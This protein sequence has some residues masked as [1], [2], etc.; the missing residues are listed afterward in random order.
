[1]NLMRRSAVTFLAY[2]VIGAATTASLGWYCAIWSGV[3][4]TSV[5]RAPNPLTAAPQ[6]L[7]L[8]ASE[9]RWL[10]RRGIDDRVTP[11]LY[12]R[13]RRGFGL[14]ITTFARTADEYWFGNLKRW[15]YGL[16]LHAFEGST[17]RH[18]RSLS[19]ASVGEWIVVYIPRILSQGVPAKPIP[20][21]FAF[22]TALIAAL[23]W[24]ARRY[25]PSTARQVRRS[26]GGILGM[27][28]LHRLRHGLCPRCTYPMGTS[29]V[30]TE[31]GAELPKRATVAT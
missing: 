18:L 29:P 10:K 3:S 13:D 8:S 19:D 20:S 22:N 12:A 21:G 23:L 25:G 6:P 27:R 26:I 4:A 28:R 16:P 24:L 7:Q 17:D 30:C 31:C 15:R 11:I 9:L 2:L 1:M 5:R 14:R